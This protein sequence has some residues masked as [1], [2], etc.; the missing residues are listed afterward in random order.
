LQFNGYLRSCRKKYN[1]TQEQLV[2]E[3]YNFDDVFKGLDTRTLIRWEKGT[4]KP[5][6]EKQVA[7][8]HL[9]QKFSTH[10][11]PCFYNQEH[12]E[13]ELCKVGIKNLIGNSKEH[14]VN[15]PS[16][17][18]SIEGINISHIRSDNNI[19]LVLDMPY[20]IFKGLT[21]N[22]FKLT[23]EVLKSWS[24]NPNN[25]FLIAQTNKQFVGMFFILRV[26]PQVFKKLLSFKMLV[27]ELR[28]DN[29]A[30]FTEE[31]C[32]FP[33]SVFAYNT[34]VASL[35]Y[36]HFYAHLIANQDTVIEVGVTPLLDGGKKLAEK[37]HLTHM[38]DKKINGKV[39]SAYSSSLENVLINKDVLKIVFLKQECPED[40]N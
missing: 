25:L 34:K 27:N 36:L 31:A 20:S 40:L 8:I 32:L 18:F 12:V 17:I 2:Q 5:T 33:I 38:L 23:L 1:L 7:I 21:S 39:I 37:M 3:L 30:N 26:K 24:L 4:T 14:I 22:Y 15:F 35:L 13:E 28:D 9:F 11:F 16:N 19:D 6:T 10:I 29:F